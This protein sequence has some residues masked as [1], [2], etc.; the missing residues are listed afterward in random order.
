M[1]LHVIGGRAHQAQPVQP[2]F[3]GP[4]MAQ[5]MVM[6]GASMA[7]QYA[8][9]IPAPQPSGLPCLCR[10]YQAARSSQGGNLRNGMKIR[11]SGK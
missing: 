4:Q 3:F 1:P 9:Q 2:L 11:E 7:A 5:G 6:T 10:V 8:G